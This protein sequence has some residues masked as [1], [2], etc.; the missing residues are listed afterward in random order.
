MCIRDRRWI[1]QIAPYPGNREQQQKVRT[2]RDMDRAV[3]QRGR[4]HADQ[5][6]TEGGARYRLDRRVDARAAL[7]HGPYRA[8]FALSAAVP[9]CLDMALSA[10]SS[11]AVAVRATARVRMHR[12]L[13]PSLSCGDAGHIA[14]RDS[15]LRPVA[16]SVTA[17]AR[18]PSAGWLAG[19]AN[20]TRLDVWP[21]RSRITVGQLR[22]GLA[23]SRRALVSA[24]ERTV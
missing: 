6:D 17:A 13:S 10:R 8:L 23:Q 12:A 24:V 15:A 4:Q 3:E 19:D 14:R 9:D 1:A 5:A 21:R 18:R 20:A 11:V 22:C 7:P 16:R 2:K